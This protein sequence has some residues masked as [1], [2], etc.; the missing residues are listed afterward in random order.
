[1]W[2]AV[3]P[4]RIDDKIAVARQREAE[5]EHG[6]RR[7]PPVP[8]WIVELGFGA[9]NPP[10][11]VHVG[12]CYAAVE[13]RRPIARDEARRMLTSG[14][15][16]CTRCRPDRHLGILELKK[17]ASDS[18]TTSRSDVRMRDG[19]CQTSLSDLAVSIRP[20]VAD[21][22]G[23]LAPPRADR[24]ASLAP[25]A[26]RGLAHLA[27]LA[28]DFP[29][30]LATAATLRRAGRRHRVEGDRWWPHGDMH[31]AADAYATART[32][33]EDHA[34]AGARATSQTQRSFTLAVTHPGPAD[35]EIDLARRLLT[36]LVLRVS[37]SPP[38]PSRPPNSSAPPAPH[39]AATRRRASRRTGAGQSCEPASLTVDSGRHAG[40]R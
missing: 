28:G 35:A 21:R 4:Q 5:Q 12:D 25:A 31:R 10:T 13:G 20:H 33:A 37:A 15:P 22:G 39:E 6:G 11:R 24:R 23:R 3:W 29:T 2:D 36:A 34:V 9:G 14:L 1:M 17:P 7:R 16:A 38:P 30:A 19:H 40:R 32:E 27:R 18:R 8:D 26:R